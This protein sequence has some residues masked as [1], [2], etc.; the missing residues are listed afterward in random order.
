MHSHDDGSRYKL[1]KTWSERTDPRSYGNISE[2]VFFAWRAR[3]MLKKKNFV[4]RKNK[5]VKYISCSQCRGRNRLINER[6]VSFY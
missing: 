1:C 3:L 5:K 2:N 6:R 4:I